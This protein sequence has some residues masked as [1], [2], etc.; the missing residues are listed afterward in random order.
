MLDRRLDALAPL[1]EIAGGFTMCAPSAARTRN[2]R[3]FS[4]IILL[5]WR[6]D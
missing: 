2:F 5:S 3:R 6:S 4:T 1:F